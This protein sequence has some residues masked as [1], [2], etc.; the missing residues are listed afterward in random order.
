MQSHT[1]THMPVRCVHKHKD[2]HFQ[3]GQ[4][5]QTL[6]DP[7][8]CARTHTHAHTDAHSQIYSPR[9]D[10]L[11]LTSLNVNNGD[12]EQIIAKGKKK[13]WAVTLS[14]AVL[15][16]Q[17]AGTF[18][19]SCQKQPRTRGRGEGTA[20]RGATTVFIRPRSRRTI[21]QQQSWHCKN[22]PA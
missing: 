22:Q 4:W 20:V 3:S 11:R 1:F 5:L 13:Q 17:Q 10:T 7:E 16:K 19:D 6:R 9:S 18:Q 14:C 12:K 15:V 2:T 21:T 8:S